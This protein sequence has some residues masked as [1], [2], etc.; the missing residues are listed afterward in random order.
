M[1]NEKRLIFICPRFAFGATVGGAETLL[2]AQAKRAQADGFNITFLTTCACDHFSWRNDIESGERVVEGLD[3]H[4]FP[5][6]E[7]RDI[8]AFLTIQEKISRKGDY[9]IEDEKT[10]LANSVNSTALCDYLHEHTDDC[11]WIII[12][13][14]LFGLT[15]FA[16]RIRPEKTIL[17]PCLHDEGF[18][19]VKSIAEMFQNAAGIMFN[20]EPEK[21]F[22]RSLY[23]LP[24]KKCSVVGMG[25]DAFESSPGAFAIKHNLHSPYIIYS[26]RREAGKGIPIMLSYAELFRARTGIDLKLVFTGAGPIEA[27]RELQPH[28]L[29]LGFVSEQ[30]KHEAMAGAAAFCHP[31]VNESFGIVLLESWLSRTPAL[32]HANCAVTRYHCRNSN[33]GLWF[34]SYPEFEEALSLLINNPALRAQLGD[35]G[36]KYVLKEYNWEKI[37]KKFS[38][39]LEKFSYS[40]F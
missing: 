29:D 4:F 14:Y 12:G 10:W 2:K 38:A 8:E 39:A 13:P 40:E 23:N 30:E 20:S 27:S 19:Y 7:N 32:V 9:N 34:S 16:S 3:V 5:V 33:G 17:V 25:L 1:Q 26:G 37:G 35:A 15:W 18:A 22:G 11:D 24:D 31:S 28:I 36:H 6:D 21:D